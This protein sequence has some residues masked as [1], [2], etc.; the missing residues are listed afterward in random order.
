MNILETAKHH[1][2]WI[3]AGVFVIGLVVIYGYTRSGSTAQTVSVGPS[4]ADLQAEVQ[5]AGIQAGSAAQQQNVSAQLQAL[6]AKNANDLAVAQLAQTVS[7]ASLTS[8]KDIAQINADVTTATSGQQLQAALAQI[9]ASLET[10]RQSSA[11]QVAIVDA[12]TAQNEFIAQGQNALQTQI[13]NNQFN[14]GAAQVNENFQAANLITTQAIHNTDTAAGVQYAQIASANQI[15]GLQTIVADQQIAAGVT[16]AGISA[17][18]AQFLSTLQAAVAGQ[19]IQ[20][21]I[22]I[23]GITAGTNQRQIDASVAIAKTNADV[24]GQAIAAN[25]QGHYYD[26][27]LSYFNTQTIANSQ[28]QIARIAGSTSTTNSFIGGITGLLGKIL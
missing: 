28:V 18:T 4:S 7:L 15:A 25:L 14:L 3:G 12:T 26:D 13:A 17:T 10:A 23:A 8:N 11:A 5:L 22:D 19:Q 16:Q 24:Q 9:A 21:N 2:Y 6:T 27:L 20:G 1:P